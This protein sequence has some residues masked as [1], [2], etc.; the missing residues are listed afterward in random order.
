M[1]DISL[2]ALIA[3]GCGWRRRHHGWRPDHREIKPTPST[4]VY[5]YYD[6]KQ[7]PVLTI[8]PGDIVRLW[9]ATGNPKYFEGL[10]VPKEKIPQELYTAFIRARNPYDGLGDRNHGGPNFVTARRRGRRTPL[11]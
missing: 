7:K 2:R 4:V 9:T 6:A 11:R 3:G 10:G 1:D 5:G 8:D